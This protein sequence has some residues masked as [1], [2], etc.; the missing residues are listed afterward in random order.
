MLRQV[1]RPGDIFWDIGANIGFYTLTASLVEENGLAWLSSRG[2]NP[3][4]PFWPIF[5]STVS[6]MFAPLK[7]RFQ[8]PRV[9]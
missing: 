8:R 1:L 5:S 4:P 3:G 2:R 9:G 7:W 6:A